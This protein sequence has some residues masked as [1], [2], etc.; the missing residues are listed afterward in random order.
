MRLPTKQL[1]SGSMAGVLN[2]TMRDHCLE[3]GTNMSTE[4]EAEPIVQMVQSVSVW[5]FASLEGWRAIKSVLY[6]ELIR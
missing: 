5:S 2:R 3:Y 4:G 6:K 1:H